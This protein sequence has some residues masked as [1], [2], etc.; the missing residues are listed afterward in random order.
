MA[1]ISKDDFRKG[2]EKTK[3]I[4]KGS[5]GEVFEVVERKS[6]KSY[7]LKSIRMKSIEQV[8]EQFQ[9]IMVL[10]K[11]Q[12]P[13]LVTLHKYYIEQCSIR[14]TSP[15]H[16]AQQGQFELG[17]MMELGLGNLGQDIQQRMQAH[18]NG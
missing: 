1:F 14:S 18:S 7:A 2:Y 15:Y 9:E 13:A 6:Q 16:L 10:F 8:G 12:H 11:I 3:V 5:F 17:I 4:G